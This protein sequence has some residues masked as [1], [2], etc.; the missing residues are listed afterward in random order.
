M[1]TSVSSAKVL[2][3][4]LEFAEANSAQVLVSSDSTRRDS[5]L[6]EAR[7]TS[8][9]ATASS[10]QLARRVGSGAI[11]DGTY[12]AQHSTTE[13]P[14]RF[15]SRSHQLMS[16]CAFVFG[17]LIFLALP[18][19][20][21]AAC[22]VPNP[23]TNGQVAD[24]TVVMGDFNA[25]KDCI[26]GKVGPTGSP[27]AGNLAV[28]SDPL[29]VAPGNISGDCV[30]AGSLSITCTKTGGTPLGYFATGTNA[31]QLSGTISTSRFGNGLNADATHFLRGDGVWALPSGGSGGAGGNW[32]FQPP[33][34]SNF[35][36]A[37]AISPTLTDDGQEGLLFDYGPLASGDIQRLAYRTLTTPTGD[38]DYIVRA[39]AYTANL[40]YSNT[41]PIM[42]MD[43][44]SGRVI[45]FGFSWNNDGIAVDRYNGLSGYSSTPTNVSWRGTAPHW[46]RVTKVGTTLTY[47]ISVSGKKW[48]QVYT[49]AS[50]AWLTNNADRVGFG[51]NMNRT[52]GPANQL[53]IQYLALTGTA[54]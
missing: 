20:A 2:D 44:V 10:S 18:G 26:N 51:I 1:P 12:R 16:V 41:Y 28:F 39:D 4:Q 54:V 48:S 13:P 52:S 45:G 35:S 42:L 17:V 30:T 36:V 32:W 27:T 3:N 34:S 47:F 25:L 38:F 46:F 6:I 49:E 43:S 50:T 40:S 15:A 37:G 5:F 7:R 11:A 9:R 53:T 8:R 21:E 33:S 22:T 31:A 14:A 19:R 24:A 23:I 29:S